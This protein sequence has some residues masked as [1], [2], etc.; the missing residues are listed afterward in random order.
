[1]KQENTKEITLLPEEESAIKNSV[2]AVIE[3]PKDMEKAVNTLSILNKTMDRLTEDKEKLTKPINTL[4]KEIRGRY[5][6]FEEQLEDTI[7]ILRKKITAYQTA[8]KKKADDEALKIA[9]RVGE[10]KGKLKIETA[11]KKIDEIDTP[12]AVVSSDQGTAKFVTVK[13]FEV[14]DLSQIPIEYHVADEVAIRK[15]MKEGKELPG[16][17]YWEEESVRNFR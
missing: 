7:G 14:V 1:M 16:V 17:R 8:A 2:T 12:D 4:L 9:G 10:G 5:K 13:K 3:T 11:V 15:A 6:P